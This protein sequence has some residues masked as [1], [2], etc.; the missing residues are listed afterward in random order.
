MGDGWGG[1]VIGGDI[2]AEGGGMKE[3]PALDERGIGGSDSFFH[4]TGK[5]RFV[6]RLSG[7]VG[8]GG[9]FCLCRRK[10]RRK[11]GCGTMD[12]TSYPR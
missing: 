5:D 9:D 2:T 7:S 3:R 1:S 10:A 8:Y 12:T 6:L 11:E 4:G